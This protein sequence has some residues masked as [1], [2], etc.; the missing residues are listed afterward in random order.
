MIL[1]DCSESLHRQLTNQAYAQRYSQ[2]EEPDRQRTSA[3]YDN[4]KRGHSG[5]DQN[6]NNPFL[7]GMN[8]V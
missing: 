6:N 3:S 5:N 2:R 1:A 8:A 7:L 4:V